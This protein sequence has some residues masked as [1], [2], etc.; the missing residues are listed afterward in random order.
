MQPKDIE[1]TTRYVP[2]DALE[3]R[4]NKSAVQSAILRGDTHV[5]LHNKEYIPDE[6]WWWDIREAGPGFQLDKSAVL[7]YQHFPV[8]HKR[9]DV[10]DAEAKRGLANMQWKG[11]MLQFIKVLAA[12][13]FGYVSLWRVWFE[14]GSSKKVVIKKG[15][16]I[17]FEAEQE[18]R[19]HL[20]YAGAE[21]TSQVV[22]LFDEAMKIR[23]DFVRENPLLPLKY[24]DGAEFDSTHMNLIVFEFLE[25][26][27][28]NGILT[29][30]AHKWSR[31]PD[32]VL[33]GIW[34]CLVRGVAA[35]AYTP[36]FR[37]LNREFETE[38]RQAEA[39]GRLEKFLR[40]LERVEISHDVHL[41][42]EEFNILAGRNAHHPHQPVFKLH[43]L[44]AFSWIMNECW[45]E[46]ME[47][48]YWRMRTPCKI[49]RVTPEQVHQEWDD[50]Q[51]D[52]PYL[53]EGKRFAGEDC[54]QGC[55]VAGRFGIWTDIFLIAKVMESVITF[56]YQSYPFNAQAY[57]ALDGLSEGKTYAW[58]LDNPAYASIAADLRDIVCQCQYELPGERPSIISLLRG[59]EA[60]KQ[61]GFTQTSDEVATFWDAFTRP[62]KPEPEPWRE[63]ETVG[64][65]LQ[66]AM[67][68]D[69]IPMVFRPSQATQR[70][71]APTQQGN[72]YPGRFYAQPVQGGFRNGPAL[73]RR[74]PDANNRGDLNPQQP[75]GGRPANLRAPQRIAGRRRGEDPAPRP[76]HGDAR[77]FSPMD[78]DDDD[79]ADINRRLRGPRRPRFAL[80]DTSYSPPAFQPMQIDTDVPQDSRPIAGSWVG[81]G[82][83][84][85]MQIDSV[86]VPQLS[87]DFSY[88]RPDTASF[89]GGLA[90]RTFQT[91]S[92]GGPNVPHRPGRS[93]SQLPNIAS[94]SGANAGLGFETISLGGPNSPRP[95]PVPKP[96]QPFSWEQTPAEHR[97]SINRVHV[98]PDDELSDASS[99]ASLPRRQPRRVVRFTSPNGN[100][101]PSRVGKRAPKDKKTVHRK[102]VTKKR[103]INEYVEK[104]LPSMPVAIRNLAM[105]TKYLDAKLV[106]K[107]IAA[108]AYVK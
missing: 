21:H 20:R 19:F 61:K 85:R 105:R 86:R 43:D 6:W 79:V 103:V 7:E 41:D 13:G 22:D 99:F 94:S 95:P 51:T 91:I 28:L 54:T 52:V 10:A 98:D 8:D 34:E 40:D 66:Q 36:P 81:A 63:P 2:W 75:T 60:R 57:Q 58:R 71:R 18:A 44:G 17:Q 50:L 37:S 78:E 12:G 69:I 14:D 35:F 11:F 102:R 29:K 76:E 89:D 68:D 5:T 83:Y 104:A 62:S 4:R 23:A 64:D 90:P 26:G 30:A 88:E 16:G 42:L 73:R 9:P 56:N 33:W 38:L 31:F 59:I 106:E 72:E 74:L 45:G 92:L 24:R 108:Y 39:E 53:E 67:D 55:E 100:V 65:A 101:R 96:R 77:S 49:H 70:P 107:A 93:G 87:R 84:D 46:F 32:R 15:V 80:A 25:H 1:V 3:D 48:D 27:D 82:P 97:M 47:K